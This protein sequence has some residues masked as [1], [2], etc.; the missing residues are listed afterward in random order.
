MVILIVL[1]KRVKQN[2]V[3]FVQKVEQVLNT[4]VQLNL[5][6]ISELTTERLPKT[7]RAKHRKFD[8]L[9]GEQLSLFAHLRRKVILCWLLSSQH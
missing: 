4:P 6:D 3:N 1:V 7:K 8:G 5:F 9:D 2:K